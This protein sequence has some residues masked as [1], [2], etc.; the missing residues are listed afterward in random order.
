VIG[1]LK[2]NDDDAST[3]SKTTSSSNDVTSFRDALRKGSCILHLDP[4]PLDSTNHSS[5][6]VARRL[7]SVLNRAGGKYKPT[8]M[9]TVT[10]Q[11]VLPRISKTGESGRMIL[12]YVFPFLFSYCS[13]S[14]TYS[15]LSLTHTHIHSYADAFFRDVVAPLEKNPDRVMSSIPE[16]V[17]KINPIDAGTFSRLPGSMGFRIVRRTSEM[18]VQRMTAQFMTIMGDDIPSYWNPMSNDVDAVLV[19]VDT[20]SLEHFAVKNHIV[21]PY[22]ESLIKVQRVQSRT[23]LQSYLTAK[24]KMYKKNKGVLNEYLLFHGTRSTN[25]NKIWNGQNDSG[26]DPR[27]GGGYYGQGAYFAEELE[28]SYDGYAYVSRGRFYV[29]ATYSLSFS[30][31]CNTHTLI[32]THRP[33]TNLSCGSIDRKFKGLRFKTGSTATSCTSTSRWRRSL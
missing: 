30:H 7:R 17:P 6:R 23:L 33:K 24:M 32:L 29:D 8:N 28:Y 10:M 20:N 11:T 12:A 16:G 31:E 15:S 14:L 21:A 27:L 1:N 4:N 18:S 19:D 22:N 9:P 25:P 3:S 26:F 5:K 2:V 13:R